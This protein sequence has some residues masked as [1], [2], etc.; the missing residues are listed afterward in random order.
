MK[1]KKY[2]SFKSLFTD[3][4]QIK[5]YVVKLQGNNLNEYRNYMY[6]LPFKEWTIDLLWE[7]IWSDMTYEQIYKILPKL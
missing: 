6:S 1:M 3:I 5:P 7:Y 4:R 2:R